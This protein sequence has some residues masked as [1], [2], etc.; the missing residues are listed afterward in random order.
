VWVRAGQAA[1]LPALSEAAATKLKMLSVVT[2]STKSKIIAYDVLM[3]ELE[4]RSTTKGPQALTFAPRPAAAYRLAPSPPAR[5]SAAC[6]RW[7]TS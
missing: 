4:A 1:Q 7:R 6:E 2:L 5:R 3:R